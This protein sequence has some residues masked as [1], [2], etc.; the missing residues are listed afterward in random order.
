LDVSGLDRNGSIVGLRC[1][2]REQ[3]AEDQFVSAVGK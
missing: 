2:W 3:E 1:E